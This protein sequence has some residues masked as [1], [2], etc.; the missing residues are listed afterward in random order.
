MYDIIILS[1]PYI[2][3]T[4]PAAA[5][6]LLKGY[7]TTQGFSVLAQD[8]N[9]VI[10]NK[11]NNDLMFGELVTYWTSEYNT[12]TLNEETQKVYDLLLEYYANEFASHN[13]RWI[14][15]SVFST[16]SRKFL[17]DFLPYFQ[18][19]NSKKTKVVL[20]GH[21][22]DVIWVDLV[23]QYIDAYI[24]G[25]GDIALK[26]LLNGNFTY[27]GINSPGVQIDDLDQLGF[28]D[29]SDYDLTIGY[30]T[31][32]DGPMIQITGSR[33]CVRDCSFCDVSS[34]WKKFK[35]R[36]GNSVAQEI[37][38]NYER[39]G[40]KNFYF[41][42]SLINGNVKELMNMM[43]ILTEYKQRTGAE[44]LWGGQWIARSQRGLSKD[45]YS[46]IKSSGGFNL[47]VGVET[48]SDSV[49]AHMKKN[50]TNEDLDVEMEQFD[51]HGIVCGFFIILEYPTET[52]EDFKDTLR[53]FKR[54]TKYVASGTITG[55][56]IGRGYTAGT[57]TPIA[58]LN[59]YSFLDDDQSPSRERHKWKSTV[60]NANYLE[61]IRRRLITQKVLNSYKWPSS[62]LEYELMPI[63]TKSDLLFDKRDQH[64][65][66]ELLLIKN[67]DIDP[68]F[69]P[70]TV[71]E[72]LDVEITL[73]G[74]KGN[75]YPTVDIQLN[76]YM[77][78][79]LTVMDE[80]TF[81]FQVK[82]CR[83][84]NL[85]KISLTNKGQFDTL[86]ENGKIIAD[87]NVFIKEFLINGVRIRQPDLLIDGRVKF[88][89][90]DNAKHDGLYANGTYTFYFEN[91]VNDYFIKKRKFYFESKLDSTKNLLNKIFK[92]FNEFVGLSS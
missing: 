15:F 35:Y 83:K 41:T 5:P 86:V 18:R 2:A 48:G 66:D 6:A 19:A 87:K 68:E 52:E 54:Y 63:I 16:H 20:G 89:T 56:A 29:Y 1:T 28:A 80:Q 53:M 39:T 11:I 8:Y 14:G 25:E 75:N 76:Q 91:P 49:R 74:N 70:V 79:N 21:G 73:V 61:N 23:S 59:V 37:I 9:V 78:A 31:W 58:K 12:I 43:R 64:R 77:H 88:A 13:T 7:L 24:S 90:G 22:L 4:A 60:T 26:E 45:Y 46:L 40:I 42:D 10:K 84:R 44:I 27:P 36:T 67:L 57:N 82:D 34:I 33:G 3:F 55:V 32:Y 62:D 38:Q 30:E 69:I 71:P 85:I 51:Q 72:M 50:F 92:M 81:K 17:E 65:V 47:T